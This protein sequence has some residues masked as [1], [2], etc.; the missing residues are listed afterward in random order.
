MPPLMIVAAGLN[1]SL[2]SHCATRP[3][4]GQKKRLVVSGFTMGFA[5]AGRS[6][7]SQAHVFSVF[8]TF[9]ACTSKGIANT[10]RSKR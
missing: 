4:I 3:C 10:I 5:P 7:P 9:C 8:G 1:V 6:K 2:F